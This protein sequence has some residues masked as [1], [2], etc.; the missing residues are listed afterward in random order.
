MKLEELKNIIRE[1]LSEASEKCTYIC[2][3]G[4]KHKAN[5]CKNGKPCEG[6]RKQICNDGPAADSQS[7]NIKEQQPLNENHP[8]CNCPAV[9]GNAAYY[10]SCEGCCQGGT[11]HAPNVGD[12]TISN[13]N[14]NNK[15]IMAR[16]NLNERFQELAGIK[17]LYKEEKEETTKEYSYEEIKDMMMNEQGEVIN[18]QLFTALGGLAAVLGAAGVTASVEMA[19]ED[20]AIAEKYPKLAKIFE[21]LQKIGGALGKGIK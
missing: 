14:N 11:L 12:K 18:E 2:K 8:G 15:K 20:P 9:G 21:F 5:C 13:N 6:N 19:L 10:R 3:N 16:E 7:G 1:T 4:V 17:P